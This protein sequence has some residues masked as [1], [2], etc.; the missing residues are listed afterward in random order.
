V[1]IG[2]LPGDGL[3]GMETQGPVR[4]GRAPELMEQWCGT[5]YLMPAW[6]HAFLKS[7]VQTSA[8]F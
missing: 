1:D 2:I 3:P 5:G 4:S 7:A 8:T 6:S